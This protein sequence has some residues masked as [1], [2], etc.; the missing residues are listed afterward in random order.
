[1]GIGFS[2]VIANIEWNSGEG[3]GWARYAGDVGMAGAIGFPAAREEGIMRAG[4]PVGVEKCGDG[5]HPLSDERRARRRRPPTTKGERRG[6]R[7]GRV[8]SYMSHLSIF[9]ASFVWA[10]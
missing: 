2:T 3:R 9:C 1:M 7:S 6:E 5:L 10:S 8:T 4:R